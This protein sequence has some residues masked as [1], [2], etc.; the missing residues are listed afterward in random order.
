MPYAPGFE[1][2]LRARAHGA[3]LDDPHLNKISPGK[4]KAMLDESSRA[5][6]Q[7]KFFRRRAA[8]SK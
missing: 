7:G 6:A 1:R 3:Q 2:A 8:E 4:A 5:K